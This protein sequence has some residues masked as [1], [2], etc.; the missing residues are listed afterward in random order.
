MGNLQSNVEACLSVTSRFDGARGGKRKQSSH[1]ASQ[2][3]D[4][5]VSLPTVEVESRGDF[6]ESA[7]A[8]DAAAVPVELVGDTDDP[9]DALAAVVAEMERAT[10]TVCAAYDMLDEAG[11]LALPDSPVAPSEEEIDAKQAPRDAAVAAKAPASTPGD[12]SS[13]LPETVPTVLEDISS[14]VEDASS[15]PPVPPVPDDAAL[16]T[17]DD[18]VPTPDVDA[19]LAKT[20][21]ASALAREE[22]GVAPDSDVA[23][24]SAVHEAC[25]DGRGASA[26]EINRVDAAR[27]ER[28]S[29]GNTQLHVA[30][31]KDL[32]RRG[33]GFPAT[34]L[35]AEQPLSQ[36]LAGGVAGGELMLHVANNRGETPLHLLCGSRDAA[37][38]ALV[39]RFLHF[40]GVAGQLA[41]RDGESQQTPLHVAC[42]GG[43][44]PAKHALVVAMLSAAEIDNSDA[45]DGWVETLDA[46]SR[47]CEDLARL[48]GDD[49]LVLLLRDFAARAEY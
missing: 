41:A 23:V 38:E 28:N 12:A 26:V 31:L 32:R 34:R 24:Q 18:A 37:A 1:A 29:D 48:G 20:S 6:V 45:L 25:R 49:A 2:P 33:G 35:V 11:A 19:A 9:A 3:K 40:G 47:S 16:A 43:A 22:S 15:V 42:G 21:A 36:L 5:A 17:A 7:T 14:L 30:L 46:E 8:E 13:T 39:S 44:S 10:P 4:D 27:W